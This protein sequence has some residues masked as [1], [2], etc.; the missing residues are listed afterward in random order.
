M[1]TKQKKKRTKRYQGIDAKQTTP[2]VTRMA[3][4]ERSPMKEWWVANGQMARLIAIAA[5][6]L[7]VIILIVTGII[8]LFQR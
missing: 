7:I 1:A 8:G 5:A 6:I 4:E 3:A 2:S